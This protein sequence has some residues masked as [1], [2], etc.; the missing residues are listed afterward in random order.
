M[1]LEEQILLYYLKV[2]SFILILISIIFFINIFY[3]KEVL[4]HKEY[5]IIE[6]N[7]K[8]SD[9]ITKNFKGNYL[10]L[11]IYKIALK[12][13][14]INNQ[15]IYY[16]IFKLNKKNNFIEFIKL[17]T[18]PGNYYQKITIVEGWSKNQLN[19]LLSKYFDKYSEFEY[20]KII[21][22]TYYFYPGVDFKEIIKL[23]NKLYIK[24]ENKYKNHELLKRF[25]FEE[26]LIIG[27]LL[28]K[29]GI[30][31]LDKKK[32]F[33]VIINRLNKK[34]KLQIDATVI[35]SL[36]AGKHKLKRPLTYNDLKI[37]HDFN[38]YYIHGLPPKPISYVGL[39]TIEL[40]FENYN[41]E[42]L[43]YFYNKYENKH[44]YSKNYIEHL[45]KLNEYRSKK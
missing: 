23:F 15:K 43:F 21:A 22:E 31:F 10:N 36:T 42:Y 6:K 13:I 11:L 7:E 37:K 24:I 39:K 29:E 17:I 25:S 40:I 12:A 5:I 34:M 28:E 41:T 30:N 2:F 4:I 33:S 8:S 35:F 32:I 45:K 14:I 1:V 3:I 26:I 16:G 44:I 27:S 38:T 19:K 9:I 20:D 18:E